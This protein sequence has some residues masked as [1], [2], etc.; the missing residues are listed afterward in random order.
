MI[1][2]LKNCV[3]ADGSTTDITITDQSI[4]SIGDSPDNA[5]VVIDIAGKTILPGVIDTHVH[6]REPGQEHKEDW[7][8]ASQAAAA[9]G[10]TSIIDMPNNATAITTNV[11]LEHKR[12]LAS[13]SI[14]NYGLY[15]GATT[16]NHAEIQS[17]YN[18]AG[19]KI[20]VGSSTGD[21]LVA[22]DSDIE[23]LL[24]IP[25]IRWVLHAED[26]N[27]IQQRTK[28][29]AQE[30]DPSVHS[31]IRDNS[32]AAKAVERIIALADKTGAPVHICHTSTREEVELIRRAKQN[33]TAITCEV[34]PHHLFLSTEVYKTLGT[35][36]KVNPPL[37]STADIE[38]LWQ[39][40]ND[41]TIDMIATDHAP[42]T[43][44]EKQQEYDT[45]P[46]GLP[47]IQTSLPLMLNATSQGKLTMT[48]LQDIMS[49]NPA[50][51]ARLRNKGKIKVGYDADLVVVDVDKKITITKDILLS[52]CN[53][54]PY[55][56]MQLVGW[57]IITI[58]NGNIIFD[59][60]TVST[61][62]Q[63]KELT[64]GTI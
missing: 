19:V 24:R 47:E 35:F 25:G 20:Y 2:V 56:E 59:K 62:Y 31:K 1:T 58:V 37:R 64:Y 55:E 13:K 34:S 10:V 5:D 6:V 4:S 45:A 8:T 16:D 49:T 63:G 43:I 57:P 41:G 12:Q 29:Y 9:G 30:R 33:G 23:K 44:E 46:A 38:A 61:K 54:S 18:I 52:K 39:G 7:L 15:L 3:L 17:A 32:V 27:I 36:A 14:V 21:L 11:L 51:I 40:I 28:E 48:K 26:E 50:R 22:K 53:W 42:H 60:S